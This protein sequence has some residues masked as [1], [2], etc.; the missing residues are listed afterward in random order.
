MKR[1][2]GKEMI[3]LGSSETGSNVKRYLDLNKVSR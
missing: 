2:K 1:M 3:Y